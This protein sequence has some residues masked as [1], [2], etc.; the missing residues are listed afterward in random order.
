MKVAIVT[1]SKYVSGVEIINLELYALVK[2]KVTVLTGSR[3]VLD[4][5][6]DAGFKTCGIQGLSSLRQSKSK[7]LSLFRLLKA[8]LML[9]KRI[10]KMKPDYIHVNSILSLFYTVLSTAGLN[11]PILLQVHDFYSKSKIE[12][13]LA[14]RLKNRVKKVVAVS[15]SVRNELIRLGFSPSQV[16]TIHNGIAGFKLPT[17]TDKQ[18]GGLT[19]G[20]VATISEWKGLHVLMESAAIL[21]RKGFKLNYSIVGP[22]LDQKY[23]E[24]VKRL[25]D[26]I[27]NSTVDF[28]G[29]RKD[30]RA[31]MGGFDIL[32][33]CSVE[34][35]PFP[36]VL[37]EGMHCRC[38]VIGAN[39]GGVPEIIKDGETGLLHRPG[40]SQSLAAA[41]ETLAVNKKLRETLAGSGYLRANKDLTIG[42]FRK[43]FIML[44]SSM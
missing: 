10:R 3:P 39:G 17:H 16:T 32:V 37:L 13:F 9:R 35:D 2:E 36:T 38:A 24:K 31:L 33:H 11:V 27:K 43:E 20:F 21:D 28:L 14:G 18:A 8:L 25:A 41:I 6:N 29:A 34:E 23:E 15:D 30:V 4:F 1:Q 7:W 44:T 40:S 22:F 26:S 5:F 42:R 12:K 19:I